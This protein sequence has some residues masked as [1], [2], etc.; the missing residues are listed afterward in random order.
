V[1]VLDEPTI[2]LDGHA[3]ERVTA[4]LRT[5]LEGRTAIVISHDP[6]LLA[7]ADRVLDLDRES[8]GAPA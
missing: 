7:A 3:A 6:A 2:G 8:L 5:L 4:A 1:V